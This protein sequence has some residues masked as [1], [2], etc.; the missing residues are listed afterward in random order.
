MVGAVHKVDMVDTV[1]AVDVADAAGAV[2]VVDMADAAG[3]AVILLGQGEGR[4][5][6]NVDHIVVTKHQKE[7]FFSDRIRCDMIIRQSII[8]RRTTTD[9]CANDWLP[10]MPSN[11]TLVSRM[12]LSYI[13]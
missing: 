11:H 8:Q 12:R 3:V 5:K 1:G 7:P 13:T 6:R 2:E 10:V 4:R 9:I